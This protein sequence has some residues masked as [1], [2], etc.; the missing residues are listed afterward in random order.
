[1]EWDSSKRSLRRHHAYRVSE[2]L[3]RKYNRHFEL[4]I[5]KY[6]TA[7]RPNP[8]EWEQK[9]RGVY[10]K[11]RKPCSCWT[12][13]NPRRWGGEVT[14]QEKRANEN[15]NEYDEEKHS[16]DPFGFWENYSSEKSI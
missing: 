14:L 4:D 10:R 11:V 6:P 8:I 2:R 15:I 9:A 12:C 1:M 5:L 7:F 3:F 13:G 16:N